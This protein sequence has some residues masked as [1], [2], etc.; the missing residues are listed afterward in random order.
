MA[1]KTL[2]L[3]AV[4]SFALVASLANFTRVAEATGTTQSAVSLKLKRLEDFLGRRLVERTP[5]SVQLTTD[6]VAFLDHAKA[7]LAANERALAVTRTA[8]HRLRLGVSDHAAGPELPM[9]LAR[10]KAADPG[11]VLEVNI[12]FSRPLLDIFDKGEL[13]GVIVRREGSHRGGEAL[14]EDEF[15]WFAAP[16]F[17]RPAGEPLRIANLAPPCGVRAVA[18]RALDAAHIPWSEAF[19]GGGIAAVCAAVSAGV[20]VAPLARRVAPIGSIDVSGALRLPKLPKSKVMLY[21]R[22]SDARGKAALRTV[23]A[24]FRGMASSS[25]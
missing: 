19:L 25:V 9:L 14:A 24:A 16:P 18:I 1:G 13:D 12:G 17:T 21:S 7:L 20:A 23:A 10:L 5:R 6:G 15:A 2:D 22:V 8:A 4:Q 11:L 3:D